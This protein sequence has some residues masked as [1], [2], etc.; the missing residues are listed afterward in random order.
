MQHVGGSCF[1]IQF[2]LACLLIGALRPFTFSFNIERCLMFSS[3]FCLPFVLFTYSLFTGLLAQK[4]LFF[5]ES[6]S[7]SSFFFYM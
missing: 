4:Y 6:S 2:A 3:H 7:H 1:L 5:V